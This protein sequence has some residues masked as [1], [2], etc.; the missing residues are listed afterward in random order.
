VDNSTTPTSPTLDA[1]QRACDALWAHRDRA[2]VQAMALDAIR[3]WRHQQQRG[4]VDFA[5]LDAVLD[6]A[7]LGDDVPLQRLNR[8][9]SLPEAVA[10]H[11]TVMDARQHALEAVR[12]VWDHVEA[13]AVREIDRHLPHPPAATVTIT[14]D[15]TALE[16]ALK[17]GR[18]K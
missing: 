14:A 10:A 13:A 2:A 1:Y 11:R 3:T 9:A 15:T 6:A 17:M 4:A 12:M 7:A 16:A 18:R 8:P 5:P